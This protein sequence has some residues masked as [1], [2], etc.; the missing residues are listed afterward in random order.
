M[1]TKERIHELVD[2]LADEPSGEA[3]DHLEWLLLDE[4]EASPGDLVEAERG[5]AQIA[6]GGYVTL[7]EL[8]RSLDL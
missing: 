3:L 2:Q 7:E 6:S 4:D 1:T 5:R 8:K